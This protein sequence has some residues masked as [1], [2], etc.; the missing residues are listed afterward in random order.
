[1]KFLVRP[2]YE[3]LPASLE[4][5]MN[6]KQWQPENILIELKVVQQLSCFVTLKKQSPSS[7]YKRLAQIVTAEERD[8]T[9]KNCNERPRIRDS[10]SLNKIPRTSFRLQT[11]CRWNKSLISS[12][13]TIR[14]S[15]E[16]AHDSQKPR[17]G[18]IEERKGKSE[19]RREENVE[20]YSR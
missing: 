9:L 1:M 7:N 10:L 8:A 4:Y 17:K 20:R 19:G 16:A 6:P 11:I 3:K 14:D 13:Q 12:T 2:N 18:R 5:K 15:V